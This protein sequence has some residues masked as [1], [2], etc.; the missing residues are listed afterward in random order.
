M[1]VK[2][3]PA[4][5]VALETQVSDA[6]PLKDALTKINSFASRGGTFWSASIHRDH[7]KTFAMHD[8][9]TAN[10]NVL[11]KL[12]VPTFAVEVLPT[13]QILLTPTVVEKKVEAPAK[14]SVKERNEDRKALAAAKRAAAPKTARPAAKK[15]PNAAERK[16]MLDAKASKPS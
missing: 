16:A 15:R 4:E 13:G 5:I 10:G 3:Q 2:N 1:P 7:L 14:K 12:D 9:T 6:K 8:E 11:P